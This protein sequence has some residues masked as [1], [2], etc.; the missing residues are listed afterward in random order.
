MVLSGAADQ[1]IQSSVHNSG[2]QDNFD[3]LSPD[4]CR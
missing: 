3:C 1:T 2:W 4:L